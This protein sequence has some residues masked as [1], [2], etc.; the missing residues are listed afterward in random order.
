M[1]QFFDEEDLPFEEDILRNAYQLKSWL[2]YIDYK[3]KNCTD[4]T[5]IYIIYERA[6]KQ[7]PKSYRLWSNYIKLRRKHLKAKCIND[8]EYDDVNDVYERA[9][10]FMNKMPRIWTEY[11]EFLLEQCLITRTRKACDR[12]LRSLPIT[13]H[14]RVWPAY[15][16]L[17]ET[18]DIPDTG[19]KVYK[20]YSKLMPENS[21]DHANY[22][23]KIGLIDECAHKYLFMLNNDDFQSKYGKSKHQLWQELCDLLSKNPTKIHTIK[24]EPILRQGIYKY[25]DQ[26][27]QLWN[28]LASYYIGLGNFE[29]ARDIYEEGLAKVLTVRDFTQIFDAYSQ[30]EESLITNLMDIAN[31]EG[32]FKYDDSQLDCSSMIHKRFKYKPLVLGWLRLS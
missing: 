6:L 15:L 26:V 22:L 19:V 14:H 25:A 2:R 7:L 32:K 18:F 30:F 23:N 20:R 24:V 4:W 5:V 8:L 17:V 16:K 10:T 3:S 28:S 27:G 31:N 1:S 13:Q 11:C 29:R 21:E 9:L 12:A